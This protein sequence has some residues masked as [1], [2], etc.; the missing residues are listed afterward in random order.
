MIED[1]ILQLCILKET[2]IHKLAKNLL[3]GKIL[4]T[5]IGILI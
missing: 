1:N 5:L 2:R 4:L 3:L